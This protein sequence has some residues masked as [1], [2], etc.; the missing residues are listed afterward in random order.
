MLVVSAT[1]FVYLVMA[2]TVAIRYEESKRLVTGEKVR[3]RKFMTQE[4]NII[5]KKIRNL[6]K[7]IQE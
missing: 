1:Q 4:E 3:V 5:P 2:D 7:L 6:C